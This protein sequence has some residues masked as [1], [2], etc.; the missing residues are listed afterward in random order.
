MKHRAEAKRERI[1]VLWRPWYDFSFHEPKD[2][3]DKPSSEPVS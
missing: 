2:E 1:C 3:M